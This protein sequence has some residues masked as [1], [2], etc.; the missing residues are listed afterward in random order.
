MC[1]AQV[2]SVP[3]GPVFGGHLKISVK[4]DMVVSGKMENCAR[5]DGKN[6]L[7]PAGNI[8]AIHLGIG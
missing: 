4:K 3:L 7:L 6:L 2:K 5:S 1:P 8:T